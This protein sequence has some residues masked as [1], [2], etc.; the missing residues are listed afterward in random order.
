MPTRGKKF[1]PEIP[2]GVI[3][4]PA[5][6][7]DQIHGITITAEIDDLSSQGYVRLTRP[8]V[9]DS[10]TK[11]RVDPLIVPYEYIHALVPSVSGALIEALDDTGDM[12]R[13]T[14]FGDFKEYNLVAGVGV[15]K[16]YIFSTPGENPRIHGTPYLRWVPKVDGQVGKAGWELLLSGASGVVLGFAQ[17]DDE[18]SFDGLAK[19]LNDN[20][21]LIA[22]GYMLSP[23][24]IA[25]LTQRTVI[26]SMR[27]ARTMPAVTT[28]KAKAVLAAADLLTPE[29]MLRDSRSKVQT[30]GK[31]RC[32]N[33]KTGTT[34]V[35]VAVALLAPARLPGEM[36][37][38]Y[39]PGFGHFDAAK[40]AAARVAKA[41]H[42][43]AHYLR[44]VAPWK[45]AATQAFTDAG[46]RVL[47]LP[48]PKWVSYRQGAESES[49][50]WVTLV[51]ELTWNSIRPAVDEALRGFSFDRYSF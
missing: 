12:L 44:E 22:L 8:G 39:R 2:Q 16:E 21:S 11:E 51:D 18:S 45:A 25:A 27:K 10:V 23:D 34:S 48:T 47:D 42:A 9:R 20:E 40:A 50:L 29:Y 3:A 7:P 14:K 38:D 31:I 13:R 36:K 32:L 46:W 5:R 19:A 28:N 1:V 17:W 30:E 37:D 26:R 6:F 4:V 35:G 24:V 41:A 33:V 49:T 43:K 15:A